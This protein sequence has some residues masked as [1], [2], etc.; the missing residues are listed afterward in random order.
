MPIYVFKLTLTEKDPGPKTLSKTLFVF[1]FCGFPFYKPAKA[2]GPIPKQT[3][4][5]RRKTHKCDVARNKKIRPK[6]NN[7]LA[8]ENTQKRLQSHQKSFEEKISGT[9]RSHILEHGFSI[10][11]IYV[12]KYQNFSGDFDSRRILYRNLLVFSNIFTN[13]GDA[14]GSSNSNDLSFCIKSSILSYFFL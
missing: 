14:S 10:F 8:Q 4:Q 12:Q 9:F 2:N 6:H 3:S 5:A 1:A 13:E 11:R 7:K